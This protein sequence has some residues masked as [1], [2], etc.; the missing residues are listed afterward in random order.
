MFGTSFVP[1]GRCRIQ[2]HWRKLSPWSGMLI[3]FQAHI[4]WTADGISIMVTFLGRRS[5]C[6]PRNSF[7]L[8]GWIM[9]RPVCECVT[10]HLCVFLVVFGCVCVFS[11]LFFCFV[12]FWFL[13]FYFI[14]FYFLEKYFWQQT[15][16]IALV[17]FKPQGAHIEYAC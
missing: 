13:Y 3:P 9:R 11:S 5:K 8:W 2:R 12:L 7:C 6:N 14:L 17:G 15:G 1:D 16:G 4:T 10:R